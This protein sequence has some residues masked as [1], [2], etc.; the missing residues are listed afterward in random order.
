MTIRATRGARLL[1]AAVIAWLGL[2]LCAQAAHATNSKVQVVKINDGGNPA[3][4][5][6]F[7]TQLTAW[8]SQIPSSFTLK[9]GETS[10][11]FQVE[12]NTG[13]NCPANLSQTITERPA[14]GYTMTAVVCR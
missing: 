12:C 3:D 6:T 9:G 13:S 8:N 11:K 10:G 4:T 2:A 5:F 14:S 7:D 1:A